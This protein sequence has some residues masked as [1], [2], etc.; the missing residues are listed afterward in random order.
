[1]EVAGVW[2][3]FWFVLCLV[4]LA[5]MTW[6]NV[7]AAGHLVAFGY[8]ELRGSHLL[9]RP[10]KFIVWPSDRLLAYWAWVV[11]GKTSLR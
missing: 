7:L 10:V 6:L 3:R 8:S 2:Y 4:F 9:L 5:G 1:M 11:A